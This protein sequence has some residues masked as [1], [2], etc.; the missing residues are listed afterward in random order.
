[1]TSLPIN[2]THLVSIPSLSSS[3]GT[4]T[5][6]NCFP[7]PLAQ[8]ILTPHLPQAADTTL[9]SVQFPAS[10]ALHPTIAKVAG[11]TTPASL[12][13]PPPLVEDEEQIA[14]H[15]RLFP[16][17]VK[18]LQP[19]ARQ[20]PD[21]L[22]GDGLIGNTVMQLLH[23]PEETLLHILSN[24]N[25]QELASGSLVC[26]HFH[27]LCSDDALWKL[28][29]LS[30]L[31]YAPPEIKNFK[32][33]CKQL[34]N[35]MHK[36][37]A[38]QTLR[39]HKEF[40]YELTHAEGMLVSRSNDGTV[41]VWNP[42][43]GE[44]L[45]S[46]KHPT[47]GMYSAHAFAEGM[48][49]LGSSSGLITM[50]NFQTEECLRVFEGHTSRLGTLV[51]SKGMLFSSARD[52]TIK[53]WNTQTGEC[54]RTYVAHANVVYDTDPNVLALVFAQKL[55]FSGSSDGMIK[56]WDPQLEQ[57]ECLRSF[58]AHTKAVQ[59]LTF[60]QGML[61]SGSSDGTIKVWDPKTEECLRTFTWHA[62]HSIYFLDAVNGMLFSASG[63]GDFSTDSIFKISDLQTGKCLSTFD[64]NYKERV[65][66]AYAF[67]FAEGML[68]QFFYQTKDGVIKAL[69][70]NATTDEI[71]N[72]IADQLF[73]DNPAEAKARLTRMPKREKDG[74]YAELH[75][76]YPH[77]D[78]NYGE[79][80]FHDKHILACSAQ[81]K[82]LA[83]HRHIA[84]KLIELFEGDAAQQELALQK[85][86]QLLPEEIRNQIYYEMYL[87]LQPFPD[88]SPTAGEDAFQS[89]PRAGKVATG[90]QRAE[91][92]ER[93]LSKRGT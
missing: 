52:G 91:A 27:Q 44:C 57:E 42:Q 56:V 10:S 38:L 39:G 33:A 75:H 35:I 88:A 9:P 80:A 54:L 40:I 70:F 78:A 13:T 43:T 84:R 81:Q 89:N 16:P 71:L 62:S 24:L 11:K 47:P 66:L 63:W 49:Y 21:A 26:K 46:I 64:F 61:F 77:P 25:G 30:K 2:T 3:I 85:F 31:S 83:I 72:N 73:N 45:R 36:R 59:N 8:R 79:L 69:N 67:T 93:Y 12:P 14:L 5:S 34:I 90:L 53:V 15:A 41:K 23:L 76:L 29:F 60:A 37:Y 74:V 50:W 6:S 82:V 17:T 22:S 68:E 7:P 28:L 86:N 58:T 65:S 4:P 92:I 20:E 55:L 19:Q 51:F 48:L 1:M 87:I 32:Q 18:S